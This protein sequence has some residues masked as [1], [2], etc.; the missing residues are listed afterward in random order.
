MDKVFVESTFEAAVVVA[1]KHIGRA[2]RILGTDGAAFM[3]R[4]YELLSS[5]NADLARS[6]LQILVKHA[7]IHVEHWDA[8]KK[9]APERKMP[10]RPTNPRGPDP[11]LLFGRN[12][13]LSVAVWRLTQENCW[14]RLSQY[15]NESKGGKCS[16]EG[17]SACD[18]AGVAW[19][20]TRAAS[21][22]RVDYGTVAKYWKK[23][24]GQAHV[25]YI[26]LWSFH[27]N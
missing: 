10:P 18:A 12:I 26:C 2:F 6:Q 25:W 11:H 19:N 8:L 24:K 17:A 3:A 23:Y 22:A 15:R 4:H 5:R 21:M 20:R 16:L 14:P 27:V 1:E 13:G 7:P 9:V